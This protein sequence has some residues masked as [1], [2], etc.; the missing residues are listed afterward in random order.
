[1]P[2]PQ[3]PNLLTVMDKLTMKN[4]YDSDPAEWSP[5]RY[6]H[7]YTT[8]Y[9]K[10]FFA[11]IWSKNICI[12][13]WRNVRF[14]ID[15]CGIVCCCKLN[16]TLVCDEHLFRQVSI[17]ASHKSTAN[18]LLHKCAPRKT[19]ARLFTLAVADDVM[20]QNEL[21]TEC[22]PFKFLVKKL[23]KNFARL[24]IF[25]LHSCAPGRLCVCQ[26]GAPS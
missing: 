9:L 17:R 12:G 6:H 4:L 5:E 24:F 19:H 8:L 20:S 14:S 15:I 21:T 26:N 1:M 7:V 10:C 2:T 16:N 3:I 23:G 11:Q 25:Q 22:F 18:V 13:E